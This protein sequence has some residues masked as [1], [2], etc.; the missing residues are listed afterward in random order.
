MAILALSLLGAACVAPEP[1]PASHAFH[2]AEGVEMARVLG[3]A[4]L[5]IEVLAAMRTSELQATLR[6]TTETLVGDRTTVLPPTGTD[7]AAMPAVLRV[8]VA[9]DRVEHDASEH[10]RAGDRRGDPDVETI[11]Y[12]TSRKALLVFELF[13]PDQHLVAML[14]V[15]AIASAVREEEIPGAWDVPILDLAF[16][17]VELFEDDRHGEFPPTPVEAAL[18]ARSC[19]QFW[20]EL[21]GSTAD[22]TSTPLTATTTTVSHRDSSH[23]GS[24]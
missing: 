18:V 20:T 7:P 13:G 11:E 5:R 24:P 9:G 23:Q 15:E 14:C 16:G 8:H 17:I 1:R 2:L 12:R 4:G 22:A 19:R 21:L 3:P 6:A 10:T